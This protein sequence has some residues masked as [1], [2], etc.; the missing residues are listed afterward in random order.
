MNKLILIMVSFLL[1]A[2]QALGQN[3]TEYGRPDELK[4]VT[5]IFVSLVFSGS[6]ELKDQDRII[7]EIKKAKKKEKLLGLMIVDRQ[8]EVEI[9]LIYSEVVDEDETE[10]KGRGLVVK[11]LSNGTHRLLMDSNRSQ[12]LRFQSAPATSFG[13]EFIKAYI[14]A[15]TATVQK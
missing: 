15:N 2:P 6:V 13:R 10:W 3:I 8:E 7:K 1:L 11:P 9:L 14:R 12:R 4:G 5:K